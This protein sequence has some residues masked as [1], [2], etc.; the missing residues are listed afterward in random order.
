[1]KTFEF[2]GRTKDGNRVTSSV[3]AMS[4]VEAM[5]RIEAMGVVPNAV[6]EKIVKADPIQAPV[7]NPAAPNVLPKNR[8][9]YRILAFLLGGLGIH[10]FYAGRNK[11][12]AMLL[13]LSV[14]SLIVFQPLVL[15]VFIII[16]Y[17]MITVQK[18]A[19][20]I[21]MTKGNL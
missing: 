4:K 19:A 15:I 7:A 10:D 5:T 1:M 9:I 16:V 17:E 21:L 12:G 13:V 8:D 3:Q 18:D 6:T 14:F 11:E 20:G 2:S